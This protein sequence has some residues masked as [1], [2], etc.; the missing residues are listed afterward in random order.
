[1]IQ[2]L[3]NTRN[4]SIVVQELEKE[5]LIYDFQINKAYCLNETLSIIFKHCNG[6]TSFEELNYQYKFTDDLI[7][8][9][10]RELQQKNLIIS[11]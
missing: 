9:A 7:Y 3:P 5:I 11:E 1:M 10:L 2:K 6:K 4:E 8:L